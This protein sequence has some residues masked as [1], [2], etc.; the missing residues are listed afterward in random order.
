LDHQNNYVGNSDIMNDVAK[1]FDILA[2]NLNVL[3]FEHLFGHPNC[4]DSLLKLFS[5]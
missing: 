5:D 4:F 3:L 1:N 2:T